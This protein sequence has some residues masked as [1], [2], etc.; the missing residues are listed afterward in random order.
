M[1]SVFISILAIVCV[2]AAILVFL[3]K[4]SSEPFDLAVKEENAGN[5]SMAFSQYMA[6]LL[7]VTD[8][9]PIPDK[10]LAMASKPD[11]WRQRLD[12]YLSWLL[13][14]KDAASPVLQTAMQAVERCNKSVGH[15]NDVYDLSIKKATLDEYRRLWKSIFFP[16][17]MQLPE[18]QQALIQKA[19]DNAVSIISLTGNVNYRYEGGFIHCVSG[20]RIDFKVFNDGNASVLL[21]PGTYFL[22]LTGKAVFPSGKTW[23][24]PQEALQIV[25]PESASI[26]SM[27]LKT[28]IK[29][30]V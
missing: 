10:A 4:K 16:E 13:S 21:A 22:T 8:P 29:R 25:I 12:D 26:I 5:F 14:T 1:K 28:D 7:R 20:K 6:S 2:S 17:G 27:K 30:R 3:S 24:S 9:R 23:T 19:V 15:V 11:A 18:N